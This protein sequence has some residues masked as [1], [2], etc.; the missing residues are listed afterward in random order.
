MVG[1]LQVAPNG[2]PLFRGNMDTPNAPYIAPS[3]PPVSRGC[4]S[5]SHPRLRPGG[6]HLEVKGSEPQITAEIQTLVP[7]GPVKYCF[8]WQGALSLSLIF[9]MYQMVLQ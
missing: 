3:Q 7:A 5:V 4:T 2:S 1:K 8:G 9:F 6:V